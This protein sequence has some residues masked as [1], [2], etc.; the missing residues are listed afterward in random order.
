MDSY[1]KR[2]TARTVKD[3]LNSVVFLVI[4]CVVG[5]FLL[6]PSG[7]ELSGGWEPPAIFSD[8]NVFANPPFNEAGNTWRSSGFGRVTKED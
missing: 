3:V 6:R 2:I 8:E 5:Y 1:T 7:S 4:V